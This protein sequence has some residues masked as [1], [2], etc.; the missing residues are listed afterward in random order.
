[1]IALAGNHLS[2]PAPP[3]GMRGRLSKKA[4]LEGIALQ[5]LH[6][7]GVNINQDFLRVIECVIHPITI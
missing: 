7:L 3:G 2:K 1:M 5:R 6:T 4:E